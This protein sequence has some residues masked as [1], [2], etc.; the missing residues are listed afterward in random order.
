MERLKVVVGEA[1]AEAAEAL[2]TVTESESTREN[3]EM[4]SELTH[5]QTV[6]R[7][8]SEHQLPL[9]TEQ[10]RMDSLVQHIK[11]NHLIEKEHLLR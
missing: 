11:G 9:A 10:K 6:D 5:L 3:M 8:C 1:R 7:L 2:E 4:K